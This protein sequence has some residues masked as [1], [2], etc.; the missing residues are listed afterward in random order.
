MS[1]LVP[2][3]AG[4]MSRSS[5]LSRTPSFLLSVSLSRPAAREGNLCWVSAAAHNRKG[6][7]GGSGGGGQRPGA[8]TWL[9][10]PLAGCALLG[11]A[12]SRDAACDAA[13]VGLDEGELPLM[14]PE[15]RRKLPA[16]GAKPDMPLYTRAGL[17]KHATLEDRVWVSY[18]D[19]VY[20]VTEF[21]EAHPG[22]QVR[23]MLA[24]GKAIDP[25]WN[26]FQQHF[27]T[28]FA[29]ETLEE[30]RIGTLAPGEWVEVELGADPYALDPLRDASLIM[31]GDKPCNAELPESKAMQAYATP[32]ALWFV[33][34]HH[35][36]PIVDENEY[37]LEVTL[38]DGS[39]KSFTLDELR[40]DFPRHEVTMTLQCS[41][42][43]R[44]HLAPFR[45]AQ[46]I[47]WNTGA[48]S[49][50][51]F[52]G[53]RLVDV[54]AK[55]GASHLEEGGANHV[56]F[57]G[58]DEMLASIPVDKAEAR[59]GDVILA[60]DMNGVPIP[61]DHGFP[62]RAVVPGH[63]GVRNVKWVSKVVVSKEE[64]EGPWQ[65]GV[66]YKGFAANV[67]D[68]KT[69]PSH[70]ID[71]A[72]A[73]QEAPVQSVIISPANN[74]EIR[75]GDLDLKGWA[76]SG[77]GRGI[78]R[79]EVSLDGGASWHLANLGEG[80]EQH[81]RRAWAWTFWSASL[82]VPPGL[83]GGSGQVMC[84]AVDASY[85]TQP[86][87]PESIWNIRGLNNTSWHSKNVRFSK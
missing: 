35:P 48:V 86:E 29:L 47:P 55:C 2:A 76:F 26:M 60:Y 70:V 10:V 62:I 78:I 9:A 67:T 23:I 63:V 77:G 82:P 38:L 56:H 37:A 73:V 3:L 69:I 13:A 25:Y 84:R 87:R 20:D 59:N 43:R 33:R 30:M 68:L 5:N 16:P 14:A 53:A 40:D 32:N 19:G 54:L 8:G 46:G 49:T 34:H 28:G 24:A 17:A 18:K 12:Q 1:R 41:G 61:P 75:G 11:F 57:V 80:S 22:G 45:P 39:K 71:S 44:S 58:L 81:L 79:V 72:I 51:Q 65:R 4:A 27:T 83:R 6:G 74:A 31:H 7:S 36:V 52:A 50:A 15:E 64:A 21:I 66:A 42:N 85:N